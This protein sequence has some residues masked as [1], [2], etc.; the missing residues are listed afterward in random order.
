MDLWCHGNLAER[1]E[2]WP[3]KSPK[4]PK[5]NPLLENLTLLTPHPQNRF[6]LCRHPI[7]PSLYHRQTV[8]ATLIKGSSIPIQRRDTG[9]T[10]ACRH[11]KPHGWTESNFCD[12]FLAVKSEPTHG[13]F[14]SLPQLV[15][16]WAFE[17]RTLNFSASENRCVIH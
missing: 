6:L 7:L 12:F 10:G 2:G 17:V 3:R 1:I 4:S 11:S 9:R 16:L 5:G 15:A 14:A 8:R 13:N